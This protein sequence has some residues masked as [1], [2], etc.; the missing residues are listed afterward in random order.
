[1]TYLGIGYS[2]DSFICVQ[3]KFWLCRKCLNVHTTLH[4]QRMRVKMRP[5]KKLSI[6]FEAM[7][8][9]NEYSSIALARL[10][11]G[12]NDCGYSLCLGCFHSSIKLDKFLEGHIQKQPMHKELLAIYPKEWYVTKAW[13]NIPCACRKYYSPEAFYA[14]HSN[15]NFLSLVGCLRD[16]SCRRPDLAYAILPSLSVG[17][18]YTL[19]TNIRLSE[20]PINADHAVPV[21]HCERC[22]VRKLF[23]LVLLS[24]VF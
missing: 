22:H 7:S 4:F 24:I 16:N 23:S 3:C 20:D 9:C 17:P 5:W 18:L 21:T 12:V 6:E 11:C 19:L 8:T 15:T 1:V 14:T 2:S 13:R 10:Q